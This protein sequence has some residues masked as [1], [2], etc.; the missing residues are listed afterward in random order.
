MEN[1]IYYVY[2]TTNITNNVL[3]IGVTNNLPKRIH[4]HKDSL[5]EG[6]SKKYKVNKLVYYETTN[7]IN[8]AIKRE[9]QLKNWKREWKMNLI[10]DNNSGFAELFID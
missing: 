6:F 3:Y 8:S 5:V 9:K 1:K 7:D 2:I 10:R 4:E